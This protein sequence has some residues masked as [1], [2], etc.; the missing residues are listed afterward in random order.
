MIFMM[1]GRV[2]LEIADTVA[3]L[4]LNDPSVLNA[5]GL[6]L[7]QDMTEALDRVE[8]SDARCLVIT[9]AGSAFCSGANLNDPDRAPRDRQAEARGEART[10]LE[11]WYH[12][13]F[14]RL[15]SLRMPIVAAINGIAAG[16]GMS[17]AL[18]GDLKIA[19][20][21]ASFLQAFARIGLVPDCGS[22]YILP[23]LIGMTR[24]LELSL[25][26]ER[27]PAVTALEWGMINRV[28][29]DAE[30][31]PAAMKL[32]AGLAAGPFSLGLIRQM[33]WQSLDNTYEQ[34]LDLEGKRQSE[35]GLTA[36]YNEGVAA[37]REKRRARF[38]GR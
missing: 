1:H 26:A 18:S 38:T 2:L 9:G 29:D 15:R 24:A 19:A 17:L 28:V 36:D 27:L 22:S 23:R 30:L 21:S 34:Q 4:T 13:T 10:D 14:L 35:A 12:P 37:F 3:V 8:A 25:L 5:F 11:L 20:R 6:K 33:Y 7:R 31:M 32:A 16:A